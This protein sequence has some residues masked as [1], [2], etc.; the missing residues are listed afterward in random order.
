MAKDAG[1][2]CY[3]RA[4]SE[5]RSLVIVSGTKKEASK[6]ARTL[7]S[8]GVTT[9]NAD[10]VEESL[11]KFTHS[12]VPTAL[13]LTNRYDGIDLPGEDCRRMVLVNAPAVMNLQEAFM[14]NRLNAYSVVRNRM[15]VRLTQAMGRCTRD[16]NDY[17]L[18]L[19]LG[20]DLTGWIAL[21][22]NSKG[23]HPELQAELDL[24]QEVS[25]GLDLAASEKLLEDFF[26]HG[27]AWNDD[28][29]VALR[30]RTKQL[31]RVLGEETAALAAT[32]E[33]E[34]LFVY[35]LWRADYSQAH[36][37]AVKITDQLG[38]PK[39]KPYRAFWEYQAA[40]AADMA[41]RL[42][43]NESHK[44]QFQKHVD[45]ASN[46][47]SGVR[48]LAS[49][50]FIRPETAPALG[51]P[52]GVD[53]V[54][55]LL[56]DWTFRGKK[57]GDHVEKVRKDV[58]VTTAALFQGGLTSLGRM[59]GFKTKS[60]DKKKKGAPDSLWWTEDGQRYVFEAKSDEKPG[61]PISYE[62]VRQAH[63]H[64]TWLDE[65]DK[66]LPPARDTK[67]IVVSPRIALDDT[68][69]GLA[70]G[71]AYLSLKDVQKL[72]EDAAACLDHVRTGCIAVS[73]DL[74]RET[75]IDGYAKEHLSGDALLKRLVGKML[76][77]LPP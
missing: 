7:R 38:D 73:E 76:D 26:E 4:V 16:K 72:F 50:S 14:R 11:D 30:A 59:L 36:H 41:Y 40:L 20:K 44:L 29:E 45:L 37:T 27:D 39:L 74:M 49:L 69:R 47:A 33:H 56:N 52:M 21:G 57:F 54:I 68:G 43:K 13:V 75:I 15:R 46:L 67:V 51:A 34:T 3:T 10:D 66:D 28:A 31:G 8:G 24:G 62:T 70:A 35:Q 63:A 23:L 48:W 22:T 60:Y 2:H 25:N 17:A 12:T 53:E 9:L 55:D 6:H 1:N 19:C 77:S 65:H 64:P 18:V 32:A 58:S 42:S 61:H 5:S 71:I